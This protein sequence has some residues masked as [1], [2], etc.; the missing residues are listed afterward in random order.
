M[1]RLRYGKAAV[2]ALASSDFILLLLIS[3]NLQ[4]AA[5]SCQSAQTALTPL[6][7]TTK[8]S[9]RLTV[10]SQHMR[11]FSLLLLPQ[12]TSYQFSGTTE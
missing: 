9:K 11:L 5:V 8:Q 3:F 6:A 4:Y 10:G 12:I 1:E 2:M 7:S